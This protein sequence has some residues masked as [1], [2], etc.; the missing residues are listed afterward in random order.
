MIYLAGPWFTPQQDEIIENIK[1]IFEQYCL[2]Y[3]SPKD[4]CL[5]EDGCD[6]T[7]ES[8][9]EENISSIRK[10]DYVFAIT[11]GKD[12]GTI[13]ECGYAYSKGVPIVYIWLGRQPGQK[14]NLM[15]AASGI[16]VAH[17]YDEVEEICD[18]FSRDGEIKPQFYSGDIE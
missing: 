7:P 12:P 4:E 18:Y 14:F 3:Y 15:L 17:S 6:F 9:L 1:D 5:F 16:R 2:E 8:V 10:S 13:W 11:D